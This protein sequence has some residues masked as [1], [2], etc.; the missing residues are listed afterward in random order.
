MEETVR[1]GGLVEKEGKKKKGKIDKD[2]HRN[3]C[4][5]GLQPLSSKS[6]CCVWDGHP[7]VLD[8]VSCLIVM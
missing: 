6:S 8:T 5:H 1:E 4:S 7:A 2:Y 3:K